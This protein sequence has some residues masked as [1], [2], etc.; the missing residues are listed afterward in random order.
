MGQASRK[1][2]ELTH[3]HAVGDARDRDLRFPVDLSF[4]KTASDSVYDDPWS[5]EERN[6]AGNW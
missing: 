2:E 6:T 4:A 5:F 1:R 3:R